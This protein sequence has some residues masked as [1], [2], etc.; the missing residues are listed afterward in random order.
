VTV[1]GRFV[2]SFGSGSAP[3]VKRSTSLHAAVGAAVGVAVG[4]GEQ[5]AHQLRWLSTAKAEKTT[6][7]QHSRRCP[8]CTLR[9]QCPQTE[10][11]KER[12]IFARI[13]ILRF[14]FK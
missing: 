8:R 7:L 14:P 4:A 13:L 12:R 2:G 11:R 1:Q 9:H 10:G 3:P 5:P 6:H